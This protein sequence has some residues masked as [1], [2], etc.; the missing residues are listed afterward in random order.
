MY[1]LDTNV[2]I[3]AVRHPDWPLCATVKRHLGKDLCI[4][5]VTYGELEYGIRKSAA[6]ERNR[7]AVTQLL[8]GI[9][10][11]PF[12]AMAAEHFGDIFSD[13]ERKGLR[14]GDRDMMIAGHARALGCTLVTNNTREFC[15]VQGLRVEDWKREVTTQPAAS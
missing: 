4:S 10:I 14:I 12:D 8:L 6:P 7:V 15:R 3:M 1:M 2:L 5:A 9:R 11:L 13:L